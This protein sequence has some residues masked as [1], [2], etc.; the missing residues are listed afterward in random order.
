MDETARCQASGAMA[1]NHAVS[2]NDMVAP[3]PSRDQLVDELMEWLDSDSLDWE[4][5]ARARREGW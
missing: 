1:R 2:F 3:P 4:A 5:V